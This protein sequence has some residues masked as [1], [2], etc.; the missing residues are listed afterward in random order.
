MGVLESPSANASLQSPQSFAPLLPPGNPVN[1]E[2]GAGSHYRPNP[3]TPSLSGVSFIP[4]I[5]NPLPVGN[6]SRSRKRRIDYVDLTHEEPEDEVAAAAANAALAGITTPKRKRTKKTNSSPSNISPS[7]SVKAEEKRLRR[8]RT[9]AP[10]SYTERLHRVRTQRMFLID[11]NRTQHE[12]GEYENEVFDIAGSTGN[13]YQV[14]ISKVPDCTCPDSEKGNQCKHIIYIL[15]NVLK[16]KEPLSYQLA[17]LSTELATIFAEAPVTPQSLSSDE[18][19]ENKEDGATRKPIEG[20]CPICMMDLE[21]NMADAIV[22]CKGAC[23]NN[24]HKHCFQQWAKTKSG[25]VKCVYCRTP[26]VVDK[27]DKNDIKSIARSGDGYVNE[28]GYVNIAAELGISDVRDTSTYHQ[29]RSRSYR[30]S[31]WRDYYDHDDYND[32]DEDGNYL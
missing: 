31:Y 7:K 17:F 8:Y 12:S 16:V 14:T 32:Y 3:N 10:S 15:V 21:P 18:A 2:H 23:G 1:P 4:P 9:H 28:E 24:V 20:D 26:W 22:W 30:R 6:P 27:N 25:D 19:A 29:P 11:R 13:I 5:G